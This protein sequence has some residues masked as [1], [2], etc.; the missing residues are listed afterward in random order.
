MVAQESTASVRDTLPGVSQAGVAARPFSLRL[1]LALVVGLSWPFLIASA[2][3][4]R[5]L[6]SGYALNATGMLMVGV[7][8]F[9]AGRYV[10]RDGFEGAG[11]GRGNLKHYLAVVGLVVTLWIVPTAI[12]LALNTVS[13]PS[14]PSD[15]QL[16]WV[17]TLVFVTLA[18][19]FGEELGWRGY[20]LP[21][22]ARRMS[23]RKAVVWHAV[24]WWAWHLPLLI[25][26]AVQIAR[27]AVDAVGAADGLSI[28]SGAAGL[29]AVGAGPAILHGVV[30]A[31]IWSRSR[32]LAVA[33]VYH[34][35]YD[36]VRD[37]LGLTVGLGPVTG[38][39]FN[40]AL[41]V[42][43]VALLWKGDWRGL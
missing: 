10:F 1:Y 16:G 26:P 20:M 5:D 12:D 35:L 19:G 15:A 8:T 21:R 3:W 38:L 27:T 32:S 2:V 28:A 34:A 11:W 39:W 18:P 30:F 31:A 4:A 23:A 40:A 14:S 17:F 41:I 6:L 9:I 37:S 25:G 22:L 13:W 24:I 42:L 33:T 43:G 7:A 36:G 29:V